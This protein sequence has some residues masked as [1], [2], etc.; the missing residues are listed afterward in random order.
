VDSRIHD[1]GAQQESVLAPDLCRQQPGPW[2]G[3]A[4]LGDSCLAATEHHADSV[5][6][7]SEVGSVRARKLPTWQK[8]L[9]ARLLA[10]GSAGT[11]R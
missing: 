2:G 7:R 11:P 6:C 10:T 1:P 8:D 3:T 5:C 4:Y 9:G